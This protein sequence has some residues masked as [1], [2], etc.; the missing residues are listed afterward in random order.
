MLNDRG[1]APYLHART[2]RLEFMET[3][4]DRE[5]WENLVNISTRIDSLITTIENTIGAS[6]ARSSA[7]QKL[8][9]V[10][11][12]IVQASRMDQQ[13]RDGGS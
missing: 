2:E 11:Q 13:Y 1:Y 8:Q 5:V 6:D 4:L 7:V 12:D 10:Y 3:P 9:D